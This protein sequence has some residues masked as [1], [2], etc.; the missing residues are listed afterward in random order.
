MGRL[1]WSAAAALV[2]LI[3]V[4]VPAQA[5]RFEKF[6]P[7]PSGVFE[8]VGFSSGEVLGNA[9]LVAMHAACQADF[10]PDSRM[11]T[12]EEYWLTPSA[13]GSGVTPAWVHPGS[14]S[15]FHGGS[16]LP[17]CNGWISTSSGVR[18]AVVDETFGPVSISELA[19][20]VARPVTCCVRLK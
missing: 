17:A 1:Q 9:G 11:C 19:C 16:A 13:A 2:A 14:S 18:G 12:V 6:I 7:P 8:F 15:G 20:D 3:V 5:Q 4:A 10:G